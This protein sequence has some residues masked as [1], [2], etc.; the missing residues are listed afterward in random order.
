MQILDPVFNCAICKKGISPQAPKVAENGKPLHKD[1]YIAKIQAG[2]Q[3]LEKA[4]AESNDSGLQKRI[5]EWIAEEKRK[6]H[7]ETQP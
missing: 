4:R 7:R 1:C 2:I 6:L 5:E 3:R